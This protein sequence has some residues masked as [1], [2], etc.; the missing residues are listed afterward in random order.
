MK[1]FAFLLI[2]GGFAFSCAFKRIFKNEKVLVQPISGNMM[3]LKDSIPNPII[4]REAEPLT[5]CERLRKEAI[6]TGI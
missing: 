5:K 6:E 4:P 3:S 1:S 2:V